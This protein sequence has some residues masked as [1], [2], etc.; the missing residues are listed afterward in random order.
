MMPRS[1][2]TAP[3]GNV[4]STAQ[5]PLATISAP[6]KEKRSKADSQPPSGKGK[7]PAMDSDPKD[8][9]VFGIN[10]NDTPPNGNIVKEQA[11]STQS[12]P[13]RDPKVATKSE[14]V[15]RDAKGS[16]H[17]SLDE[18]KIGLLSYERV[19]HLNAEVR[20]EK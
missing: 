10:M 4:G 14:E 3:A 20:A 1:K 6:S 11:K 8:F 9:N 19:Y 16:E 5:A 15:M 18:M 2:R 12:T 17:W 13:A 7:S